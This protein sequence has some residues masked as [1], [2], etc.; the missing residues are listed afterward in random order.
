[1]CVPT[2]MKSELIISKNQV[3]TYVESHT[4]SVNTFCCQNT[5]CLNAD[6]SGT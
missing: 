3:A 6:E 2:T 1:M 5:D 4:K